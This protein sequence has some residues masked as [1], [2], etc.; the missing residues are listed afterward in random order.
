MSKHGIRQKAKIYKYKWKTANKNQATLCSLANPFPNY[1]VSSKGSHKQGITSYLRGENPELTW[2]LA[3]E[4]T[5]PLGQALALPVPWGRRAGAD[6]ESPGVVSVGHRA[7]TLLTRQE[8]RA[9]GYFGDCSAGK[10]SLGNA[11]L[12]EV[13]PCLSLFFRYIGDSWFQA[14]LLCVA[15]LFHSVLLC[16]LALIGKQQSENPTKWQKWE[17]VIMSI[18]YFHL[19]IS[20][21]LSITKTL[22][23]S[24]LEHRCH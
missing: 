9:G 14:C 3:A 13:S 21:C 11:D 1:A 16:L 6:T 7:A 22:I 23:K 19:C 10:K 18:V 4:L 8:A 20:W 12:K 17:S 2:T 5:Y 24:N 15:H